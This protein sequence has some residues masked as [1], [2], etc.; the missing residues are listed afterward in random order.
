MTDV[1]ILTGPTMGTRFSVR[2]A[3][4]ARIDAAALTAAIQAAVDRVDG[5]MSTWKPQ[6]DLCR[7]NRAMPGQWVP[8]PL[9][10]AHV[11]AL[12]LGISAETDGAFDMTLGRLVELWG[13]GPGGQPG[14]VPS[15]ARVAEALA[16]SGWRKL[17][18]NAEASALSKSASLGL[19]LSGI[20]KGFGVDE[21]AGV[22]EE[23]GIGDYVAEIDG[24]LRVAGARPDGKSWRL[25]VALPVPGLMAA[26]TVIAPGTTAIAT[27]GDYRHFFDAG[28]RHY[29]HTIDGRTGGPV[30]NDVASVT[31]LDGSCARAD[32]LASALLVMGV[33]KGAAFAEARG[34]RALFLTRGDGEIGVRMAGGFERVVAG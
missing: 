9:E 27:S 1:T 23:H 29:A 26:H 24:E 16:L 28:A 31:V 30:E 19:D 4:P 14:A 32:A 18:L 17:A 34:V 6:S 13:F 22:L 33:E 20:A 15:P 8:I 10:M 21:I 11:V 12:G 7:F 2:T 3:L 5:Q 25:A